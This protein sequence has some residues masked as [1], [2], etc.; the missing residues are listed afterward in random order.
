VT[1]AGAAISPATAVDVPAI[2]DLIGRVYAE[3][4][5]VFNPRVEV[6]DLFAFDAHY[7]PPRGA[8]FVVRQGDTIVGSVGVERVDADTAE[9]HRLYLDAERRG[10]GTGRALVEV[11]LAWCRAGG[12]S[13]MI[14]WSDT[15]FDRAHRLYLKMGFHQS[16]ERTLPDDLNDTREYGF[17]RAV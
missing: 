12:F 16:G 2:V 3:Y 6:P 5:F 1:S 14:L 17:A 4:G 13:R 10:Q 7:T 15:R 11:A 9:L 8:F